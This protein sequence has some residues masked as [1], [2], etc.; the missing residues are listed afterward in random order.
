MNHT[1]ITAGICGLLLA[2]A[3]VTAGCTTNSGGTATP[4]ATPSPAP[5]LTTSAPAACGFT[6]CHGL[7]LACSTDFPRVCT[8]QYQI[9]DRCRQYASCQS[10]SGGCTLV[11]GPEFTACK[12]CVEKCQTSAGPNGMTALS[13]EEKC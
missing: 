4:A 8:M 13:C 9:G 5:V 12:T 1:A 3:L 10:G 2:A 6:T 11:A 7:D